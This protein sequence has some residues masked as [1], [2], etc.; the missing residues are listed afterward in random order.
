VRH[1]FVEHVP[2]QLEEDVVYVSIAFAT[3]VHKCA[4]GCGKEVV[5]PLSPTDWKL[6]FDGESISLHPS[7]GNW[8]FPCRAHYWIRNNT[9]KWAAKWSDEEIENGRARDRSNKARFYEEKS[10]ATELDTPLDDARDAQKSGPTDL[11]ATSNA[12]TAT[13]MRD[14][15]WMRMRRWWSNW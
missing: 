11:V 7:I 1:E 8:S 12:S 13:K 6:T 9:V 3:A 5:T 10:A 15:L 14:G 2:E 4:C